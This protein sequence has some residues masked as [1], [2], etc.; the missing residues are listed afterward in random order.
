[1]AQR[2]ETTVCLN[3][4]N[5]DV[6]AYPEPN[7]FVLD[8]KDRFEAQAVILSSLEMP[9]NQHIIEDGWN[10]F[11][12]DVG[13]SLWGGQRRL[14]LMRRTGPAA[15]E[16]VTVTAAPQPYLALAHKGGGRW[17]VPAGSPPDDHGL[18]QETLPLF[19]VVEVLFFGPGTE[20][21]LRRLPVLEVDA[22]SLE[23]VTADP[24]T[25][26]RGMGCLACT[27]SGVRSFRTPSQLAE[28]LRA[29]LAARGVPL[30]FGY[31]APSMRLFYR[32]RVAGDWR[33]AE[34]DAG[35]GGLLR[36][37]GFSGGMRHEEDVQFP[38]RGAVAVELPV[39]HYSDAPMLAKVAEMRLDG[40]AASCQLPKAAEFALRVWGAEEPF[41]VRVAPALLWH[42][43]ALARHV[44]D[45]IGRAVPA[46]AGCR[47]LLRYAD[48]GGGRFVLE[49]SPADALFRLVFPESSGDLEFRLGF[50]EADHALLTSRVEGRPRH[51]AP[52]P[53][54]ATFAHSWEGVPTSMRRSF[55]L[56][57]V[58]RLQAPA[59]ADAVETASGP[60]V[61]LGA[62]PPE[63]LLW[64]EDEAGG[65]VR[66]YVLGSPAHD[67]VALSPLGGS[68]DPAAAATR[69]VTAVPAT[70][71]AAV[72]LYFPPKRAE[73]WSRLAEIFGFRSGANLCGPRALIAP[74]HWNLDPPPYLLLEFSL[75]HMSASLQ[76]RFQNDVKQ[77]LGKVVCYPAL[78]MERGYP[79]QKTGTGTSVISQ[80]HV[81]VLNPW[82]E[83][84]RFHG[85]NWSC[86]VVFASQAALVATTCG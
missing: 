71:S 35:A 29:A 84:Y 55:V 27:S 45:A 1:M 26:V 67:L 85:R 48:E 57:A 15:W 58:P 65:G 12:F 36:H 64:S 8:L 47:F 23:I 69:R 7:D 62:L 9:F 70:G 73:T 56:R 22:A 60:A 49:A 82:H 53:S 59:A 20:A 81:R 17:S 46:G 66:W 2:Q 50:D 78:R 21:G 19:G 41:L 4:L 37:L 39:G 38:Q 80:L 77:L 63:H 40:A 5:R 61:A 32:C 28:V 75:P 43:A 34:E 86:S 33:S 11:S 79:L 51:F 30:L 74:A 72:N 52:L 16:R 83:L 14:H 44:N 10:S 68:G 25:A 24:A 3:T 31:D 6:H 42:P 76:H 54:A 18:V 13:L